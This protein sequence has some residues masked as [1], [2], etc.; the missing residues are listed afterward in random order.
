MKKI[1]ATFDPGKRWQEFE[2]FV[3]CTYPTGSYDLDWREAKRGTFVFYGEDAKEIREMLTKSAPL[4]EV[5]V[6]KIAEQDLTDEEWETI[7]GDLD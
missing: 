6:K 5:K 7:E 1:K 4:Y 2:D 3:L